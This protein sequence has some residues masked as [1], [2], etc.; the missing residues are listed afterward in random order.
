MLIKWT[1]NEIILIVCVAILVFIVPMVIHICYTLDLKNEFFH[2]KWECGDALQYCGAIIT[3]LVAIEGVYISLK[4]NRKN[5]LENKILEHRPYLK[6]ELI[7]L[8]NFTELE[9]I[10][11][12]NNFVWIWS[13]NSTNLYS[14]SNIYGKQ[15][16]LDFNYESDIQDNFVILVYDLDNIGLGHAL[17]F[18][19]TINLTSVLDK[20]IICKNEKKRLYI[21]I[22]KKLIG[23]NGMYIDFKLEYK[24]I[25][26]VNIYSQYEN[27]FINCEKVKKEIVYKVSSVDGLSEPLIIEKKVFK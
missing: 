17:N 5:N 14:L 1:R 26:D 21:L 20:E 25:I 4:E 11:D 18:N 19:L 23:K 15:Q 27:I 24:D 10:E 7:N 8:Y 9:K 16:I 12:N 13:E 22:S 3:A 2:S 6:S